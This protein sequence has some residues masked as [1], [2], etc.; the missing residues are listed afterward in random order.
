MSNEK[1]TKVSGL[2]RNRYILITLALTVIV[3]IGAI[4]GIIAASGESDTPTEPSQMS[5]EEPTEV[6]QLPTDKSTEPTVEATDA[7]EAT[8][9]PTE[10]T[11]APTSAPY[12]PPQPPAPTIPPKTVLSLPYNIPGTTLVVQ[13]VA[14]YSGIYLEDASNSEVTD[15]AM[16]L[17]YNSGSEPVELAQLTLVYD[18]KTLQFKA[19]AIPAG[20]RVAVQEIDRKSCAV[21]DLTKCTV[22]LATMPFMEMSTEL[23]KIEDNGNNSLTVT[24]LTEQDIVTVRI[25][26]KYY[27]AEENAYI[28]GIAFS[29]KLSNLKAGESVVVAPRH[30]SSDGSQIVMVRTYD[31]DV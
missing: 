24:N 29:A 21:G 5:T 27:L 20:G 12:V 14:N 26:Y 7:T 2:L 31:V 28:G 1:Y 9:E 30:Y 11:T 6:T 18:D 4:I 10:D 17:L 3:V 25:F 22:D 8:Q 23:V 16:M 13:R 19:S 15:V